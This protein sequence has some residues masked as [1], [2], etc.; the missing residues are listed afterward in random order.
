MPVALEDKLRHIIQ[1]AYTNAPAVKAIFA[2]AKLSPDD[3]RSLADMDK[4]PVTSKDR[5][6][7]LQQAHLPFGGFL[8]VPPGALQHILHVIVSKGD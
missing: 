3:I 2:E 6:A 5:L 8:A 1:H 7:E 4:I